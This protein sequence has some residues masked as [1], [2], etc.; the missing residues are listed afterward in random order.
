MRSKNKPVQ[1]ANE[2]EWVSALA[3]QGCVICGASP[4]EIHEFDQGLWFTAVPLCPTHHRH[5]VQG[6][7][8]QRLGWKLARMDKDKAINLAVSRNWEALRG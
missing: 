6:W 7:H 8:G 4:V 1:T 2:R 3:Q 5:E